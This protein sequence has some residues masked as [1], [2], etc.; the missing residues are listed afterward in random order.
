[1]QTMP[2]FN[3]QQLI[4]AAFENRANLPQAAT[5]QLRQAVHE[6]L[7]MLDRG[8][9]RVAEKTAN[10]WQIWE[11]VKKAVLLSFRLNDNVMIA[12]GPSHPDRG[13]SFWYDKVPSK[14]CGWDQAH[15]RSA[16]IRAV[17]GSFVRHS[18][19]IGRNT[20]IMPSF[21][22]L[23]AY[24][25]DGT[26]IDIWALIGSCAQ[27][28]K[29]CHISAS[30]GIGG[31][32]EPL[33]AA[34]V[35]IED[36]CFIGAGAQ[37]TEGTIIETGA[38]IASGTII[39]ASTKIIDRQTGTIYQGRVPAYSVVVPGSLPGQALPDGSPGPG[40]NCAVIVK[41]VDA[42]TRRKTAINELLR[43]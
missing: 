38:V 28:G 36:E 16:G 27:I 43:D 13:D 8:Q 24:I 11:W 21:I 9:L 3:H 29:N 17:P 6:V 33:Q 39:G 14:F 40:L 42:E 4:E 26:M 20:V 12:G 19:Y 32:I 34:P 18:A 5:A 22:N 37:I 7:E 15:F 2:K 31:V 25:D 23:G 1:M 10:G 30:V 35:I 41:K